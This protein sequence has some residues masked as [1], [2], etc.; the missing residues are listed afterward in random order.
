MNNFLARNRWAVLARLVM[1]LLLFALAIAVPRACA[2]DND[3]QD[4]DSY[5][6]RIDAFWFFSN[7][8]GNIQG[9]GENGTIDI[10]KDLGFNSYSTFSGLVDWKFTRKNHFTFAVSPFQQ[11]RETV[12]K[13][14]ITYQGQT[15]DV[16]LVTHA[17]LRANLY[18]PGYQYDIIRRRRGHLGVDVQLDLF[19]TK[20]SL[21][22]QAQ[23]TDDGVH[24]VAVSGSGSLT[25]PIP[26]AG[27]TYRLYLT[28][29]PRLF[30]EGNVY[31]M[32]LFGYG[33][34]I[35]TADTLGLTVNKHLS[36][37]A[38]CSLGSRLVVNN[39]SSDRIGVHLTQ[40]G[41]LMG[42]EASF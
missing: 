34:F 36:V 13:R 6:I 23:T 26:V 21:S 5:K 35:S 14:T 38:G 22:A 8:G 3:Q 17:E 30:V 12:L 37:N 1:A 39:N 28:D 32:Y 15:F 25:A 41:A 4:F 27:P 29:S 9:S 33:N 20:A 19:D 18:S 16:G 42:L 31:G 7:P 11:N 10:Q 40:Q 2:A 24:H